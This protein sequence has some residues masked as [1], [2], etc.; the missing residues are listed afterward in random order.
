MSD[1]PFLM[2][3]EPDEDATSVRDRLSF[4]RGKRVLLVWP[5]DGTVLRR[6]LDLVL[7]Q[8]EAMRRAVRLALV[9]HDPQVAKNAAE[10]NI[11]TFETIGESETKRWK[12]ARSKVFTGRD[13]KPD[14]EP[15]PEELQDVASRVKPP[16]EVNPLRQTL[17]RLGVAFALVALVVGVA[18]VVFPTATVTITPASDPIETTVVIT[19]SPDVTDINIEQALVPLTV[20]RVEAVQNGTV[21]TTGIQSLSDSRAGG[22]VVFLNRTGAGVEIPEGTVVST[23]A[24]EPIQ[25]RTVET[26]TVNAGAGQQI[27]VAIE[28][29][30]DFAGAIGNVNEGLINTVVGPLAGSIEVR[31][32]Q[33]TSG[34]SSQTAMAVGESD[35]TRLESMIRQQI[36]SQAFTEMQ[37]LLSES[38]F[39][40]L[41]T[42]RIVE[43][44]DDWKT[45]SANV[46]EVADTVTLEMRAVVEAAAV[47]E[48]H[49]RQVA[50]A[51]L[52]RGIPRGRVIA[53][54]S[55]EYQRGTDVQPAENGIAFD[56]TVN[57]TVT[58]PVEQ[59][60]IRRQIAAMPISE[61]LGYIIS[62]INMQQGTVPQISIS[63][64]WMR[65]MPV[66]PF[67]IQIQLEEAT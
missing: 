32:V 39:I 29:L 61:A 50:F 37:P 64:A 18:Y 31:N 38:Q 15:E 4:V 60:E 25:F 30:Q 42:L 65:Q 5:E 11:S 47:D 45:Y 20:L 59:D 22:T 53:P 56:L 48:T 54:D 16:A 19:A 23:S 9:T 58:E 66:L 17:V 36:Q 35:I 2:Q 49:G 43:E 46:G 40:I 67:R 8:R 3:L 57:A 27:E 21:E 52:S 41:D 34:G 14:S 33:P 13:Q 10:L 1:R 24:G 26:V 6:K 51:S 28:A 55:I 7:I 63:P 12:R 62:E 44:R